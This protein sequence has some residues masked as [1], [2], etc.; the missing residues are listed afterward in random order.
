MAFAEINTVRAITGVTET[1]YDDPSVQTFIDMAQKE[2]TSKI[3]LKVIREMI[4]Y[5]DPT[6]ENQIDGSNKKY[7]LSK[8]KG[9]FLG[10]LDL[11]SDIDVDDVIVYHVASDGTETILSVAS[12]N[13]S[14]LSVTLSSAPVSGTLYITYCYSAFNMESPDPALSLATTYLAASY[15]SIT[16]DDAGSIRF[17]NVSISGGSSSNSQNRFYQK[18]SELLNQLIEDSSGGAIWGESLVQI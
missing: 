1:S 4:L 9:N 14:E 18:Y 17:G 2:I 5:L 10:D 8:W 11:D 12:V 7:Y 16:E 13:P 15:L 3:Q 6:R